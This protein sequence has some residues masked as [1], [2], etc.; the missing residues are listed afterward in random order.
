VVVFLFVAMSKPQSEGGSRLAASTAF[1]QSGQGRNVRSIELTPLCDKTVTSAAELFQLS[2]P[3]GAALHTT[4][5]Y[6]GSKSAL[7]GG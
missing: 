3:G 6:P 5:V 4:L 1:V 2:F 7:I